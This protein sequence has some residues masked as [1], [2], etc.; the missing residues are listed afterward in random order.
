MVQCGAWQPFFC[1]CNKANFLRCSIECKSIEWNSW[2]Y[3]SAPELAPLRD[4]PAMIPVLY[5]H[6]R[7]TLLEPSTNPL[8]VST[9]CLSTFL[10]RSLLQ[11]ALT[12]ACCVPNF[13]HGT[14]GASPDVCIPR[15]CLENHPDLVFSGP[16]SVHRG[17]RQNYQSFQRR[18][19]SGFSNNWNSPSSLLKNFHTSFLPTLTLGSS[20]L[21]KTIRGQN[22]VFIALLE[23][24]LAPWEALQWGPQCWPQTLYFYLV[25]P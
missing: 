22:L 19:R 4:P 10:L 1:I 16:V 25:E 7:L 11:T 8:R 23:C 5:L 3:P 15:R 21:S 24:L 6:S 14:P 20:A 9:H 12:F 18:G 2:P 13:P 17:L